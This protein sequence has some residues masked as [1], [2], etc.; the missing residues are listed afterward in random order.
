MRANKHKAP[1]DDNDKENAAPLTGSGARVSRKR[2]RQRVDEPQAGSSRCSFPA[3]Q[4]GFTSDSGADNAN[5]EARNLAPTFLLKPHFLEED[6]GN[7]VVFICRLFAAPQ[8][9]VAWL[10]DEA[11]VVRSARICERFTELD[12]NVF[13]SQLQV[14][15]VCEA[16]AGSYTLYAKNAFGDVSSSIQFDF[17]PTNNCK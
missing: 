1:S 11:R 10:K 7:R 8:P 13:A 3:K 9:V 17:I 15:D 14:N 5:C 6:D 16:D 2:V 12:T 4:I